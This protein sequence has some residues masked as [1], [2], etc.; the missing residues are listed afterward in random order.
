MEVGAVFRIINEASP[1]LAEM[2]KQVRA[3]NRAIKQATEGMAAMGASLPNLKLGATT[4]EVDALAASWRGVAKASA[5]AR[6]AMGRAASPAAI[7][8]TAAA[9]TTGRHRPS[10]LSRGNAHISG[11]S[12]PLAGGSHLRLGGGPALAAGGTLAW[13]IDQAA[14]TDDYAWQLEDITGLD[15]NESNHA[16]FRKILQNAQIQTGFGLD[17]VGKAALADIRQ[18]QTLPDKG[19]GNLM[20]MINSA[21]TEARR[22]GSGLEE[23]MES[24]V[25]LAHQFRAYTPESIKNLFATFA[26]LST[27]DPRSLTS[28]SR[29]AGYAVPSLSELGVDPTSVLLAGTGLA[30]AGISS[31]K[32]GT[33]LGEAVT[34]AMPGVVL[35]H[36]ALNSKHEEALKA[37]GLVGQD[38]KPTWYTA[39]HPDIFKMFSTAGAAMQGM[40][41]EQRA[42][43]GRAAFGAQGSRAVAI[44]GDPVV[45]EQMKTIQGILGLVGL[46]QAIRR[47]RRRLPG[48]IHDAG[49]SHGA[50]GVQRY[51][52]RTGTAH[53]AGRQQSAG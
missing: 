12:V 6:L 41:P 34:R 1:A 2:L 25:A 27:T 39:G 43:Y 50:A 33:W 26:A 11:P 16:K 46:S 49:G 19:V 40:R 29:A 9:G 31:T 13:G 24:G 8:A 47:V 21:A 44:M 23:S 48:R 20:E 38:G 17:E 52:R 15:H 5:E 37:L 30:R 42:V 53:L 22:K 4:G 3:L 36:K 32:S 51:G 7:S 28:M 35:G 10:W 18:M 14:K 45:N